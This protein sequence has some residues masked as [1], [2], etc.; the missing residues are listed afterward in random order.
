MRRS[1]YRQTRLNISYNRPHDTVEASGFAKLGV[2]GWWRCNPYPE[3]CKEYLMSK[4]EHS[5]HYEYDE[6][7]PFSFSSITDS[8]Y[9]QQRPWRHVMGSDPQ[10][11]V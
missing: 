4:S 6:D 10:T 11:P 2:W 1:Y 7:K 3:W 5:V 8:R 9:V